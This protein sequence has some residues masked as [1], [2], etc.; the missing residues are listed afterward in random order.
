MKLIIND[1]RIAATATDD[2]DG[3]N[4]FI[5]AP[6]DFDPFTVDRYAVIGDALVEKV[7]EIVSRFQARAALFNAGLF[8]QV[9]TLIAN[10]TTDPLVKFAWADAQEFRRSSPTIASL[11]AALGM[12]DEQVDDLFKAAQKITA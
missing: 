1:G 7:P 8:E 12:T 10:P 5:T 2:Y 11:A 3:P 6:E 4:K 9:E